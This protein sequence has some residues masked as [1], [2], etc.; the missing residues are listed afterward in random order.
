MLASSSMEA[1]L[2][3]LLLDGTA[4]LKLSEIDSPRLEAELL[5][6][7]VLSCRRID[8]YTN[9]DQ[10]ISSVE[11]RRFWGYLERRCLNEPLQYITESVEFCGRVLHVRPGVFIPRPETELIVEAAEKIK[12]APRRILDLCT[13]SAALAIALACSY[14]TARVIASDISRSA[15]EV[16]RINILRHGCSS[17]ISLVRGD[18]FVPFKAHHHEAS[19]DQQGF[20]LIVCNPPYISE[21]DRSSL[22]ANVRD[23]EPDIALY[24]S[25]EGRAFYDH[26][27]SIAPAMLSQQGTLLLELG[28]G[29]ADWL[30]ARL[31]KEDQLD[32]SFIA[33]WAN[34]DRVAKISKRTLES[35]KWVSNG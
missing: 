22:P 7:D 9:P 8:L 4:F 3:S 11:H 28:M 31:K 10:G 23:H 24:A 2:S 14:P 27:I 25:D 6:S 34:I 13:G 15:L 17:Q 18:R 20:D 12:I 26:I 32:V 33:D 5:L 1:S 29:Q 19:V 16:A 21:S 30:R 35:G